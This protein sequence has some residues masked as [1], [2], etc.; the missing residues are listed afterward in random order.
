MGLGSGMIG[1]SDIKNDDGM[2][3]ILRALLAQE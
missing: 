1:A 3:K 2:D